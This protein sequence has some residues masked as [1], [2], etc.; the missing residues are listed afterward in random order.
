[1]NLLIKPG[2]AELARKIDMKQQQ[3]ESEKE[4]KLRLRLDSAL[5]SKSLGGTSSGSVSTVGSMAKKLNV[6]ERDGEI[7]SDNWYL[8]ILKRC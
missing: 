3:A 1:M 6:K 8:N 4:K 7:W 2:D 5:D